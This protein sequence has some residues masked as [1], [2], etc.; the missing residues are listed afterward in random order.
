M[1]KTSVV[2]IVKTLYVRI[3]RSI[4]KHPLFKPS[5]NY[6]VTIDYDGKITLTPTQ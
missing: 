5:S 2:V 1:T 3:P 6:K 4:V